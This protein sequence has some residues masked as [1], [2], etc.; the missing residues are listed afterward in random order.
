ML[1][2]I[3]FDGDYCDDPVWELFILQ[4]Q[5]NVSFGLFARFMEVVLVPLVKLYGGRVL[6]AT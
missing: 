1:S 5:Y 6:E 2:A 3:L 4:P